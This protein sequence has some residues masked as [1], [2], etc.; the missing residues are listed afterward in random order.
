M[1]SWT[2]SRKR[3][4]RRGPDRPPIA[5][6]LVLDARLKGDVGVLSADL[7][8][9]LFPGVILSDNSMLTP[10]PGHVPVLTRLRAAEDGTHKDEAVCHVAVSPHSVP[11]YR[12]PDLVMPWTILA[13]RKPVHSQQD[14]Q[15]R[16]SLRF[17]ATS[18]ALTSFVQHLQKTAINI[19][20]LAMQSSIDIFVLDVA[21][22]ALD[23]IV[24]SLDEDTLAKLEAANHKFRRGQTPNG[25]LRG[26]SRQ[27]SHSLSNTLIPDDRWAGAIRTSLKAHHVVHTRDMLPLPLPSHPITHV[28]PPPALVDLCEPVSQGLVT[29]DTRVVV[30]ASPKPHKPTPKSPTYM[31]NGTLAE[32]EDDTSNEQFY[33]AAEDK[34]ST[35]GSVRQSSASEATDTE[36]SNDDDTDLSD[37]EADALGLSLPSLPAPPSGTFSS[38]TA[39]TP[40]LSNPFLD[41]MQSP[42][43]VVSGFSMSTVMG[44][45]SRGKLFEAH[46]LLTHIPPQLLHPKPHQ[47]D[48]EEARAYIDTALLSKIGCFSGDWVRVEAATDEGLHNL[49]SWGFNLDSSDEDPPEWRVLRIYALPGQSSKRPKYAIN[50]TATKRMSR[51]FMQVDKS[52]P[53]IHL[54][55][56]TLANLGS[57]TNL[58]VAKLDVYPAKR[59]SRLGPLSSTLPTPPT[60]RD[61]TLQKFSTPVA[62]ERNLDAS[63]KWALE[64]HFTRNQR[65]VKAGDLI[66]VSIDEALGRAMHSGSTEDDAVQR[67]LI[68]MSEAELVSA[69]DGEKVVAW[70]RVSSVHSDNDDVESPWGPLA[71]VKPQVTKLS[72]AGDYH[73][74]LPSIM[75]NPWMF[76]L[77]CKRLPA[78]ADDGVEE[79]DQMPT[80]PRP[81]VSPLRRRLRE[82]LSVATSPQ[83]ISNSLPPLA[84]LIQSTQRHIGKTFTTKAAC[85]DLGLHAFEIDA[86]DIVS[87][88]GSGGGDVKTAGFLEA[89]AER[90][91]LSRAENTC[92][93]IQHIDVLSADRM[94]AA[95]KDLVARSRVLV[96]TTTAVDKIPDSMR[97]IFSHELEMSAP[98]EGE[99]EG[100]LGQIVQ[101]LSMPIAANVELSAVA[102]KTAALVAG[103][104]QDVVLRAS[105]ARQLRLATLVASSKEKLPLADLEPRVRDIQIAGGAAS[106][107][108]TKADFDAAVDAARKNFADS[109]GAPK[110]PNVT[111]DDVGGLSGVKDAVMETIQLP[112]ERPEL[113]AKGMKKRSGILFYGPP[114]TGKTLL[115]KAIATEFSL[116]FFSVKGPE[117]LNMYIGESEANVRRVF[118][119]ARDA[120]PC[121][122]FFDELDSVAPKRGNQGD[123][124]GVMDRIVSQLLAELDGMGGGDDG[125]AGGV[126]VIGATNRP[127]LL[128]QALLRPGRFD[129]MLYL[130]VSDTTD[131]QLTILEALTRKY[132][133]PLLY[134]TRAS[135]TLPQVHTPPVAVASSCGR[136]A[137]VHIHRCRSVRSLLRRHAQGHH[138]SCIG[139]RRQGQ[140]PQRRARFETKAQRI[141]VG[142]RLF[143]NW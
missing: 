140:E 4:R 15:A 37:G 104:L 21:P 120:R 101:D 126:F 134:Y 41:G 122:V 29:D 118:Q 28:A 143:G 95:V 6:Q 81:Y 8:A 19:G 135:L 99:R 42:G 50:K 133:H 1:D 62:H 12:Q 56:L 132:D 112:L 16:Y 63:L 76:Y 141:S 69:G 27:R 22:I 32:E 106:R 108:V 57:P 90:G 131:K 82:L 18:G 75:S 111:W 103:D 2:Q 60:A 23:T 97:S 121:V 73:G 72:Q 11:T 93:V 26:A 77:G 9:D 54:S 83:A 35:P 33:S 96:A 10:G 5:A 65:L 74:R 113:F 47:E 70:F 139:G 102:L 94:V 115:A 31:T 17:P 127:D 46:G 125:S 136:A 107:R 119:R 92:L 40:R 114:G 20:R 38:F 66:G 68:A 45:G 51:S 49:G 91:L 59:M 100:I 43:S 123:S 137:T 124:G 64:K 88:G 110:I 98:D 109:I 13:V 34:S 48:D 78:P 116:N 89:R 80:M 14:Q 128:D 85:A 61:V 30:M 39:A 24:L 129:K 58:R 36:A 71:L 67:D 25:S 79:V 142:F 53:K 52:A 3:K 105:V 55:P 44:G 7:F 117:L 138:P 84:L 86:Y 130:G 87:E